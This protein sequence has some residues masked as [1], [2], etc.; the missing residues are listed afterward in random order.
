M[1]SDSDS[2]SDPEWLKDLPLRSEEIGYSPDEMTA[3]PRCGRPNA[4]NRA[5]CLYCGAETDGAHATKLDVRELD[6]WENGFNV[7][8]VNTRDANLDSAARELAFMLRSEGELLKPILNA[9]RPLPLA[10]LESE[11]QAAAISE[12]LS[13]FGIEALIVADTALQPMTPPIRLRS[14]SFEDSELGLTLFGSGEV[15]AVKREDIAL[16][17]LGVIFEERTES[18]ERRKRRTA[19]TI[20]E[21]H[22]SSDELVVDIYS[23]LDS[24]GWRIPSSGFD[25]SCLGSEKS[26]LVGENMERLIAKL[27]EFSPAARLVDSYVDV[28]STLEHCWPSELRKDAQRL[29]LGSKD[30]SSVLSTNNATQLTRYSRLQWHLL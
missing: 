21:F 9:G 11:G 8:V 12:K 10:R 19:K 5:S 2:N 30:F 15:R 25:F 14:V 20:S 22:A 1:A 3:C 23:T 26:L 27:V 29:G 13:A 6:S 7:V 28:R 18:I 4:P 17:V 16:I 24:T